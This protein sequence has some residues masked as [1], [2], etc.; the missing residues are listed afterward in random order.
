MKM[1]K[2]AIAIAATTL[3]GSTAM[4]YAATRPVDIVSKLTGKSVEAL[5]QERQSGKTYGTIAKEA[6]KLDEFK[7][8][9]LKEKKAL[10]DERVKSGVLTQAQAD[11]IYNAIKNN[12]VTCDGTGTAK[13]GQKYGVGFGHGMGMG[14]GR[15]QG[16]RNGYGRGA[17][18]GFGFRMNQN[19]NK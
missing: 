4:A 16:L 5:Y 6:G 19:L 10:L 17:A 13:I 2:F 18:N 7:A 1:K 9:M 15:G 12:Q 8:E 14:Q 3:I 11:E